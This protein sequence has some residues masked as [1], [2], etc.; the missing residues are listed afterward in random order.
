MTT[1]INSPREQGENNGN[2][3]SGG[4]GVL[5]G[6]VVV[7]LVLVVGIILALPYLRQRFNSVTSPVVNNP[8]INVQLPLTTLSTTTR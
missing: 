1:I 5:I 3:A 4:A 7:V 8:T 6:A 2:N